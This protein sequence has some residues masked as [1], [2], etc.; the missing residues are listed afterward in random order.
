MN[1]VAYYSNDFSNISMK[2]SMMSKYVY[3]TFYTEIK[4][5]IF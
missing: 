5:N 3:K 1:T 4:G 2:L